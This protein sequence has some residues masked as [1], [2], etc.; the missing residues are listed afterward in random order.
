[1]AES[2]SATAVVRISSASFDPSRLAE[3]K[4]EYERRGMGRSNRRYG[5]VVRD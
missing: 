5:Y 4:A 1:M 3:L 2:L